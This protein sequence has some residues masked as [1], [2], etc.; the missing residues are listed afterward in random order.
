MLNMM[1]KLNCTLQKS[2]ISRKCVDRMDSITLEK[3]LKKDPSMK[4][5]FRGVFSRD[6]LPRHRCARLY[7]VNEEPSN[8]RG[9]HWIMLHITPGKEKNVYFDSYGRKPLL[10]E[11]RRYLGKNV[12]YNKKCLQHMLSMSCGQWCMY[13]A[14][15]QSNDWSLK[16]ITGAFNEKKPLVNDYAMNFLVQKRFKM[17]QNVLD[18]KFLAGQISRQMK[19]VLQRELKK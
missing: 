17:K 1:L 10:S 7:V 11:F 13:F 16:N 4:H 12:E 6:N 15:R 5:F 18:R 8:K 2:E 3:L 19:D 9:S 14:W